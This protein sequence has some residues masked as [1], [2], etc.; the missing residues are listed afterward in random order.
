M[1]SDWD[2][3]DD[4]L[5]VERKVEENDKLYQTMPSPLPTSSSLSLITAASSSDSTSDYKTAATSDKTLTQ[6]Y[7]PDSLNSK[8]ESETNLLSEPDTT[9]TLKPEDYED[10]RKRVQREFLTNTNELRTSNDGTMKVNQPIDPSRI[11]DSMKLYGQN[12]MSKSFNGVLSSPNHSQYEIEFENALRQYETMHHVISLE[13]DEKIKYSRRMRGGGGR[14]GLQKSES[15][16]TCTT[17]EQNKG[18]SSSDTIVGSL[19]KS[20]SGPNCFRGSEV[21]DDSDIDDLDEEATLRPSTMRR[22]R[23]PKS[24]SIKMD[25]YDELEDTTNSTGFENEDGVVLRKP[26][27]T[28]STAIKRRSGNRRSRTKLKRRCSING[29]FYNRETSFFTPPHGAVMSVWATSL[30]DT[31]QIINLI[32]EKYKV[33]KKVLGWLE[34]WNLYWVVH[35]AILQC[36]TQC[37]GFNL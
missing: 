21:E 20:K 30:V 3:I 34:G 26:P 29:H 28:G 8:Q 18:S 27:K 23:E 10:F 13:N 24:I 6:D 7:T 11:N 1:S 36:S 37:L 2:E 15:S 19:S 22:H 12:I 33:R 25:C 5:Q 31:R 4:L 35:Y 14:P 17:A 32:L 16:S 9:S